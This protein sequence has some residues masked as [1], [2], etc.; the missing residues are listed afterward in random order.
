MP[1]YLVAATLWVRAGEE[2]EF[3]RF[4]K[5]SLA[6]AARHSGRLLHAARLSSTA[7]GEETPYELHLLAFE[8]AQEFAEF[9]SDPESLALDSFR[10][11]VIAKAEIVT[12]YEC[13]P[14]EQ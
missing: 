4:E 3:R 5:I 9:R 7:R 12:G 1:K 2:L 14:T 8:G 6:I 13:D 11:R 10:K